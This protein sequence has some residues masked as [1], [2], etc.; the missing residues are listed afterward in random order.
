MTINRLTAMRRWAAIAAL[1]ALTGCATYPDGSGTYMAG[2][3][4]API[5]SGWYGYD[6]FGIGGWGYPFGHDWGHHGGDF[7]HQ[8]ALHDGGL[9]FGWHGAP[10]GLGH[11]GG[12]HAG[13]AHVGMAGHFGGGHGRA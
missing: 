5:D 10:G 12:M 1:L 7:H 2:Y 6:G 8:V 13:F 3:Y 11:V 4:D 9:H